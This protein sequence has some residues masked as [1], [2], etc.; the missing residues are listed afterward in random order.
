MG[1]SASALRC[2]HFIVQEPMRGCERAAAH[3]LSSNLGVAED[4]MRSSCRAGE[5]LP[6]SGETLF[7]DGRGDVEDM[8]WNCRRV[9][10]EPIWKC[11]GIAEELQIILWGQRKIRGGL[12]TRCRGLVV[13]LAKRCCGASNGLQQ[14]F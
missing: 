3:V 4:Q 10:L 6:T 7:T 13:G 14:R 9:F 11:S 1:T 5:E 12:L 2:N 8:L